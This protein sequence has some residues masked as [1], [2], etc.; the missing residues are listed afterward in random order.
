MSHLQAIVLPEPA[1]QMPSKNEKNM[2][3]ICGHD[4]IKATVEFLK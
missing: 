3:T 4:H 2:M 1:V